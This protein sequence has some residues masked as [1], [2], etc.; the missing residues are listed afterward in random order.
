MTQSSGRSLPEIRGIIADLDGVVYRGNTPVDSAVRSFAA[1]REAGI[2]YCF[3]TNNSTRTTEEVADKLT[4]MGVAA[5]PDQIVSS[6][7]GTS[8]FLRRT[9]PTGGRA[10]VLGAPSLVHAVQE[11][12]FEIAAERVDC[13]VVGLDRHLSYQRL[14]QA[15][16]LV[17][18]GAVLI[19]TNPDILLPKDNG[20][21][22]GAGSILAAIVAATHVKPLI[23]GKPQPHLIHDAI[24][25]LGIDHA[26]AI[27]IGDQLETDIAAA[28]IAG[29]FAVLVETGVPNP[30][31][32]QVIP[33][34]IVPTLT[35]LEQM[36]VLPTRS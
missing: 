7:T 14:D 34:L 20:F 3:V 28:Q 11:A 27:M 16:G 36:M 31:S 1:W 26:Q 24:S 29:V 19:G 8:N 9:W 32:S 10:F 12:G 30:A 33:D 22:P 4:A 23:V 13:V 35:I 5:G 18:A 2:P 25:R 6:A 15:V 17:L 21:E